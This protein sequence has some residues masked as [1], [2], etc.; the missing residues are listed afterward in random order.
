[1]GDSLV[2]SK[3]FCCGDVMITVVVVIYEKITGYQS[4]ELG[5]DHGLAVSLQCGNSAE[6]SSSFRSK[7]ANLH[8]LG[9][10]NKSC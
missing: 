5:L 1:M 3:G 2:E 10:L 4:L 7:N 6:M 8:L 9:K